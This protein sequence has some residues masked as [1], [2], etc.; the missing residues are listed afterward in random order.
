MADR[1]INL[2]RST[3]IVSIA[4]ALSRV[5]G[6]IS[7]LFI[8]EALGYSRLQD[9]YNLANMMPNMIYELIAGGI[10]TSILIPI[11]ITS[12]VTVGEDEWR[13][14]SNI[15][16]IAILFL[17]GIA[18]L[19]SIFSYYFVRVQTFLVPTDK[20]SIAQLN[21][22]FKFF[23]WEIVFYGLTALLNGIL[24][25]HRRFTMPALA[26]IFNN[27]VVIL[28]IVLFYLPL[29]ESNPDLAL[30]ALALG[31]T[32]GIAAM[33]LVQLPALFKIGWQYHA[34]IDFRDPAFRQLSVLALPVVV[35]VASNQIGLTVSNALAWQFTGGVT[36][37][38]YGWRFFQM[39]YGLLAASISTVLFPDFAEQAAKSDF[40]GFKETLSKAISATAFII[41]PVSIGLFL[42]SS[43]IFILIF[44]NILGKF[45]VT[46]A[47]QIS[48]VMAYFVLGLLP[49]S[50]FMLFNRVFYSLK[51]TRTSMKVNALGVPLN[52]GLNFLL[53]SY[54]GVAGLAMG[55][56]LTYL[57]TMSLLIYLLKKRIGPINGRALLLKTTKFALISAVMGIII[58][59][60]DNLT[61]FALAFSET[62]ENLIVLLISTALGGTIYIA[63]NKALGTEEVRFLPKMIRGILGRAGKS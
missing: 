32:L 55:H 57:A 63:L 45:T 27:V 30:I 48:E 14:F 6:F 22:F 3:G 54:F 35:Y 4:T 28:T 13:A 17:V 25:A 50:L 23:V 56:S 1:K 20:V 44:T 11:F 7:L 40:R 2:S 34:V 51:D 39:P 29:K 31:T 33:A 42:L 43:K 9:S 37:F 53:V 12:R 38:L 49:F 61:P 21:F 36:A 26:P 62:T 16:N 47:V 59:I 8:A 52:I 60:V 41:I 18:L 5:T 46:D 24:Q 58:V 15:M 19:G 10:L